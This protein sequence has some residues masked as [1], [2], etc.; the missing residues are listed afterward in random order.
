LASS[1]RPSS[2]RPL[3][4][5]LV[6]LASLE[7]D[8][9]TAVTAAFTKAATLVPND[10]LVRLM[11]PNAI[12]DRLFMT[13]IAADRLSARGC[14]RCR[15]MTSLRWCAL[16]RPGIRERE[17]GCAAGRALRFP[18][19]GQCNHQLRIATLIVRAY[20]SAQ[21]AITGI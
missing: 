19:V 5:T 20:G 15:S 11:P 4:P 16:P 1:L 2:I 8:D 7:R 3:L 6:E 21:A 18:L 9:R 13:V 14:T 10:P 12:G 17:W